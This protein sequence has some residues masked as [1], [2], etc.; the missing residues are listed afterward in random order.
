M[1]LFVQLADMIYINDM[2][3][4]NDIIIMYTVVQMTQ[5]YMFKMILLTVR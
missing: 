2:I 4:Y 3:Q 1:I 5:R